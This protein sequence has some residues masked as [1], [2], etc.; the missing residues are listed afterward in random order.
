MHHQ[1]VDPTPVPGVDRALIDEVPDIT[2]ND[3]SESWSATPPAVLIIPEPRPRRRLLSAGPILFLLSTAVLAVAVRLPELIRPDR[4]ATTASF[5]STGQPGSPELEDTREKVQSAST[6]AQPE[7][8]NSAVVDV[9]PIEPEFAIASTLVETDPSVA[10]TVHIDSDRDHTRPAAWP[11]EPPGRNHVPEALVPEVAHAGQE[12]NPVDQTEAQRTDRAWAEIRRESERVAAE[13]DA[14][15]DLKSNILQQEAMTKH[16]RAAKNRADFL[17]RL[18]ELTSRRGAS[19]ETLMHEAPRPDL[20]TQNEKPRLLALSRSQKLRLSWIVR[21]RAMGIEEPAILDELSRAHALNAS[22]RGGPTTFDEAARR[23]AVEILAA[24]TNVPP[25]Q[26]TPP[27]PVAREGS[28]R[29]PAPSRPSG[30]P[31]SSPSRRR[32]SS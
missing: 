23:A 19:L 5:S 8:E 29:I 11:P 22:A 12:Q 18:Q 17:K 26:E 13:R 16:E 9:L 32:I 25:L 30:S 31:A 14:L 15:T 24:P 21:L 27:P 6:E 2:V 1:P 20:L 4:P 28:R 10:A 3:S 7:P